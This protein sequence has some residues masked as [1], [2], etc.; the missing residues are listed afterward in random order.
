MSSKSVIIVLLVLFAF[1]VQGLNVEKNST[2]SLWN[3]SDVVDFYI[4]INNTGTENITNINIT[5]I[6]NET[7][8]SYLNASLTP[9]ST[10]GNISWVLDYLLLPNETF[11]I[12]LSFEALLGGNISNTVNVTVF[13]NASNV[14]SMVTNV[15]VEILKND[16]N[17]SIIKTVQDPTIF[18]NSTAA[19]TINISNTGGR[20]TNIS[21]IDSFNLTFLSPAWSSHNYTQVN[22][23][24]TWTVN[25]SAYLEIL[26][27]FTAISVGYTN[28]TVNISNGT[29]LDISWD[30]V[31]ISLYSPPVI[32]NLTINTTNESAT[33]NWT[34]DELTN[35]SVK[36]G[37]TTSLGNIVTNTSFLLN[38]TLTLTI[39]SNTTIYFNITS[40]DS[41][42]ACSEQAGN[43][44]T[45]ETDNTPPLT[46]GSF[47]AGWISTNFT[48][49]FSATDN[50]GINY[51]TFSINGTWFNG[52]NYTF[53][54]S[55]NFSVQ[56]Y[57]VD[58]Y[59]N[60]EVTRN[61][62][63]LID[64]TPPTAPS[65]SGQNFTNTVY[66]ITWLNSTDA[67][68]GIASYLIQTANN[69]LFINATNLTSVVN[70]YEISLVEGEHYLR[71]RGIDNVGLNSS[72]SWHNVTVDTT[73]PVINA[74]PSGNFTSMNVS[75]NLSIWWNVT[76][77][78]FDT[79]LYSLDSQSWQTGAQNSNIMLNLTAGYHAFRLKANDSATNEYTRLL[80]FIINSPMNVTEITDMIKDRMNDTIDIDDVDLVLHDNGTVNLSNGTHFVNDTLNISIVMENLTVKVTNFEG[81][82]VFWNASPSINL[83]IDTILNTTITDLGSSPKW[84]VTVNVSD[85]ILG[86][87]QGEMVFNTSGFNYSYVYY[88]NGTCQKLTACGSAPCFT[89]V[90]DTLKVYVTGFS[91]VIVSLDDIIGTVN[92]SSPMNDTNG[93]D[94]S[95]DFVTTEDVRIMNCTLDG[96]ELSYATT[97]GTAFSVDLFGSLQN[98]VFANGDYN[99]SL[100]LNDTAGNAEWIN[101][102]FSVNDTT[103]PA[104]DILPTTSSYSHKNKKLDISVSITSDEF[105]NYTYIYNDVEYN[106]S[107]DLGADKKVSFAIRLLRGTN[108]LTINLTDRHGNSN[109]TTK[110]ITLTKKEDSS[111]D[112]SSESTKDQA[113]INLETKFSKSWSSIN[114]G[115]EIPFE[116]SNDYIPIRSI[117]F[118]LKDQASGVSLTVVMLSDKPSN[119][120]SLD[121]HYNYMNVYTG[122]VIS[123]NVD[124]AKFSF[125]VPKTWLAEKGLSKNAISLY[126]FSDGWNELAT[127]AVVDTDLYQYFEAT[128]EG[129]SYFAIA[130]KSDIPE[131]TIPDTAAQPNVTDVAP[132]VQDLAA[133]SG[134]ET[135]TKRE[136]KVDDSLIK[137]I[138]IIVLLSALISGLIIYM[139]NKY[140]DTLLGD[141]TLGK[142]KKSSSIYSIRLKYYIL[143]SRKLGKTDKQI[144]KELIDTGWPEETI[145]KYIK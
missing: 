46:V 123:T 55:G 113:L 73:L 20:A 68:S 138:L 10:V 106:T 132:Q 74:T 70:Y 81:L 22:N 37:N 26:V 24:L 64:K 129:F 91:T 134:N 139:R 82:D 90:N 130:E 117:L 1:T 101:Y 83:S 9:N 99:I 19:F 131:A 52:T 109:V 28:N 63:V 15:S 66:N 84:M 13:D 76:D 51:T 118:K 32:S 71:V 40:C 104:Y 58:N 135:E 53:N 38:H 103:G 7:Q 95:F 44:T 94:L 67:H 43:F 116:V 79:L 36:Y 11:R 97:T 143:K 23:T 57:S 3:R 120:D 25:I 85:F 17:L 87:Y 77:T 59:S 41:L 78:Y 86:Q 18:N 128:S 124:F 144:K 127:T 122:G 30:E 72:W 137:I 111:S 136:P 93:E 108:N 5:D 119:V 2:Q 145:K 33:I 125:R 142:P 110:I 105:A 126:R 69:S 112:E 102:S 42:G 21:V 75:Q 61:G 14:T 107:K 27:N 60:K 39:P 47:V 88:C 4:I 50:S 54:K 35:T 121:N 6:F 89:D 65:M 80:E 133:I 16:Y 12:N 56:Y 98:D 8:L 48:L 114:G 115:D 140:R 141:R 34:T 31:N 49:N 45:L 92:V 62:T 100:Y 29:M 96:V